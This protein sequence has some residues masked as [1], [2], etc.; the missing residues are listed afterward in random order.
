[1]PFH[2]SILYN[3]NLETKELGTADQLCRALIIL[4]SAFVHSA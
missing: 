4:C 2:L 1:M 3:D